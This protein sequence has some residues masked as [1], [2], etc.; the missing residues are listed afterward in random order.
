MPLAYGALASSNPSVDR[1]GPLMPAGSNTNVVRGLVEVE[2][3][4]V[5][6]QEP[7]RAVV[8]VRVAPTAE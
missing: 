1:Y 2:P 3:R 7:E 8:A 4:E 5:L 6:D